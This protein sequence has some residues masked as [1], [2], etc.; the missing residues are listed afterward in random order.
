MDVIC[1]QPGGNTVAFTADTT[2]PSPVHVT[3]S[4]TWAPPNMQYRVLTVGSGVVHLG[5]GTSAA[6]ATANASVVTSSGAAIPL[7]P[8]TDEIL[9][10]PPNAYFT[11]ITASGTVI[12]Y[13]TPGTG[14]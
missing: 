1:F 13:I 14:L 10:F 7:Q 5:I 8:G 9:S 4:G 2:A 11:G 3:I 12:V 6:A